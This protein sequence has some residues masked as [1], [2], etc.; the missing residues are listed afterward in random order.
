MTLCISVRGKPKI[1]SSPNVESYN[2]KVKAPT[3]RTVTEKQFP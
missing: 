2:G 3:L 1:K